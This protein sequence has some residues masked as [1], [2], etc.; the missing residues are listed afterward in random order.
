MDMGTVRS[1]ADRLG[2]R[3]RAFTAKDRAGALE[4]LAAS[5]AF[6]EEEIRVAAG[7]VD[8]ALADPEGY[9]ILAGEVDGETRGF[10]CGGS[11]PLTASTWHLYWI[12]V[13]PEEAGRGLGRELQSRFE[14]AARERGARRV[15]V[16]TSGRADY[17]RARRFYEAAGYRRAGEIPDYYDDGDTCVLYWKELE[18]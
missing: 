7:V 6:R 8:D 3:V 4:C 1:T 17:A 5:G 13:H 2:L 18:S 14:A 9:L 11:T 15:V 12:C 10:V 16:E